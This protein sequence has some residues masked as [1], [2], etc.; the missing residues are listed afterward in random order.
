MEN[1]YCVKLNFS[2]PLHLGR[3]T[4]DTYDTGSR[5]LH[6]DTLSA[7]VASARVQL[8][9]DKNLKTFLESFRV[10]S[11]FPYLGN[12]CFF[13]KPMVKLP[14]TVAGEDAHQLTKKLKKLE[15]LEQPLF[16]KLI[17]GET[18]TVQP[19]QFSK[20]KR[21]LWA[22]KAPEKTFLK[23]EVQQRV[24]V[25]RDG[26]GESIPYYVERLFFADDAGLFFLT[27][28]D[29]EKTLRETE[30]ALKYLGETGIGTDRTVGNGFFESEIKPFK[31][32]LP[33]ASE[34]QLSLSLFCPEKEELTG[35]LQGEPA[36]LLEK[37]G[38]FIAGASGEQFR[39][40]RKKS[41][42]MFTEGSVFKAGKLNG[43][44][45]DLR[46]EWDNN[47]LHPVYRSGKPLSIPIIKT[48]DELV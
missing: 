46:P 30:T 28:F 42:F 31:L 10:S 16:E 22:G 4:S 41:V 36:Y 40:L 29:D 33:A 3:G 34:Y 6:S 14:L 37:R 35:L 9:G 21:Y 18:L 23:T 19:E 13:P 32:Q 27:A 39:H 2:A 20:N 5:F 47:E 45:L 38:G 7:A 17:T 48:Q 1:L 44:V 26:Q 15:Y 8:F 12:R 43:K 11:A 24:T 25:P